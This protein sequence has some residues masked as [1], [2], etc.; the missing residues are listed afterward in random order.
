MTVKILMLLILIMN[1]CSISETNQ[2]K[3]IYGL[4]NNSFVKFD[5]LF[6]F[7]RNITLTKNLNLLL[8]IDNTFIR[9]TK[10]STAICFPLC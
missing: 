2:S 1:V 5:L 9:F 3:T 10:L 4:T 6:T 8:T 7:L